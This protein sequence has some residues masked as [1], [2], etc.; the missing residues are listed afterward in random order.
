MTGGNGGGALSTFAST[1]AFRRSLT[2]SEDSSEGNRDLSVEPSRRQAAL[3]VLLQLL[4]KLLEALI[5]RL[6]ADNK[7]EPVLTLDFAFHSWGSSIDPWVLSYMTTNARNCSIL[8]E[9]GLPGTKEAKPKY[10]GFLPLVPSPDLQT[11]E[12][13]AYQAA[14]EVA[15]AAVEVPVDKAP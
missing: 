11:G 15:G 12:P 4:N 13:W 3:Q 8:H 7:S 2:G 1:S 6:V 9:F 14:A 10:P 5:G